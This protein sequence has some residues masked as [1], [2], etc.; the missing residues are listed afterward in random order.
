M[1]PDVLPIDTATTAPA[2]MPIGT[3]LQPI[4]KLPAERH[5]GSHQKKFTVCVVA[6]F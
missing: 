4:E 5:P 6:R 2:P 3:D 1:L